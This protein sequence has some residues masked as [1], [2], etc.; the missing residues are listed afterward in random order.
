[1]SISPLNTIDTAVAAGIVWVNAAGNQAKNTWFKRRP[2]SYSTIS[3]DGQDTKVI[4]FDGTDFKNRFHFWGSPIELRWDDTWS[5]ATRNLDLLLARP[6]AGEF[7]LKGI[8]PQSGEAGHYPY[9][10]VKP[11]DAVNFDIL[12]AHRGG[13]EP[14]WIQLLAWKGPGRLRFNTQ[15]VGSIINPAESANPGMLAVGA[16]HWN[17]VNTIRDYSSRGPTPDGRVKPDI[18]G[19]DCGETAARTTPFCGTSQASPHVAG[20]AALV[21]QRFPNYTPAQVVSY[22]KDNAQQPQQRIS[23]PDP[24]YIWG[25]RIHRSSSNH[26]TA[27]DTHTKRSGHSNWRF[28]SSGHWLAH[29]LMAR[30]CPDRQRV[31]HRLRPAPHTQ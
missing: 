24:N 20:M 3:V 29:R 15:G 21:R 7:R 27:P 11:R 31:R 28:G 12:I 18:V 8:D 22:L 6:G 2:F 23:S 10:S 17:K 25:A 14:G 26:P 30:A 16:A 19:A 5:G 1:M 9:E 13:S 4:N